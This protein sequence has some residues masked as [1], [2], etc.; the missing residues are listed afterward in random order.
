MLPY[1]VELRTVLLRGGAKGRE[2][3]HAEIERIVIYPPETP[4]PSAMAE[5]G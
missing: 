1:L 3:L 2:L 4:K 5:V